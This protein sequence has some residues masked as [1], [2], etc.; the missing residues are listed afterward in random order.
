[1]GNHNQLHNFSFHSTSADTF[2]SNRLPTTGT[3]T[4]IVPLNAASDCLAPPQPT[5]GEWKLHKDFC[6]GNTDCVVSEGT[7]LQPGSHLVY[8]CVPG[9]K[10][11]GISEVHCRLD[12]TW[13][14]IPT[15]IG[16]WRNIHLSHH[17]NEVYV[18]LTLQLRGIQN[19]VGNICSTKN[20]S[21]GIC[22]LLKR[23]D[24][25]LQGLKSGH[26]PENTCGFAGL[27]PI[28]CCPTS[29]FIRTTTLM[30]LPGVKELSSDGR[31]AISRLSKDLFLAHNT[32]DK[33]CF[34]SRMLGV[35]QICQRFG[36]YNAWWRTSSHINVNCW[37]SEGS[38]NGISAH[39]CSRV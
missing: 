36:L 11:E 37:K 30:S 34:G 22:T 13:T 5:N 9:F 26:G 27:Q 25:V 23:C 32:E 19:I 1:M 12:G 7:A 18:K 3:P 38:S 24:P 8:S 39:G 2:G 20:G 6:E 28:V 31:G 33:S 35:L 16:K 17:W 15:C 29:T 14:A 4:Q 21:S 10:M